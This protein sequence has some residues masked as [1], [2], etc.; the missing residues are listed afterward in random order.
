MGENKEGRKTYVEPSLEKCEKLL[1][2]TELAVAVS[3]VTP[4]PPPPPS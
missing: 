1:E 3:G 2:I 4:P